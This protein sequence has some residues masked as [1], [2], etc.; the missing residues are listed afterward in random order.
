MYV[1]AVNIRAT[2]VELTSERRALIIKKLTPLGRYVP[3]GEVADIDVVMRQERHR[4]GGDKFYLTVKLTY[5][6]GSYYAVAIESS[7]GRALIKTRDIIQ[8]ALAQGST[9]KQFALQGGRLHVIDHY[10]LLLGN[11]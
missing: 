2:N 8:R 1:P 9:R 11:H 3:A 6:S 10:R 7:L 5:A 4:F